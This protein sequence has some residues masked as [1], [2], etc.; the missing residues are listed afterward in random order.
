MRKKL[1]SLPLLGFRTP[2]RAIGSPRRQRIGEGPRAMAG[3]ERGRGRGGRSPGGGGGRGRRGR[4]ES[5][6]NSR[7]PRQNTRGD[8]AE[9][10][11]NWY[12]SVFYIDLMQGGSMLTMDGGWVG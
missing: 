7:R 4:R 11:S 3:Q 8:R 1:P 12:L 9:K 10:T 6:E 2:A 5:G